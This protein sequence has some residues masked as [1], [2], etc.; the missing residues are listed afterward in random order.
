MTV[1]R[2]QRLTLYADG[3]ARGNPGP[4]GIG[5]W[6][7][8]ETGATVGEVSRFIGQATN[9]QAEYRALIA[10]LAH[11]L[12]QGARAVEVRMDSELVIKQLTGEYRVRNPGLRPLH[13]RARE[14]AGRFVSITYRW[15]PRELN[16][17]ADALANQVIDEHPPERTALDSSPGEG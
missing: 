2:S 13:A 16:S 8:D 6:I 5:A 12:N 11:L 14:L 15:I 4:A 7:T 17:R 1:A 3:A 9:N 10:G